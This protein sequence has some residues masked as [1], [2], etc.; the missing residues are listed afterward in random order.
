VGCATGRSAA[1][2]LIHAVFSHRRTD[3]AGACNQRKARARQIRARRLLPR[4]GSP[5]RRR[6]ADDRDPRMRS[7]AAPRPARSDWRPSD[8][9][10][11]LRRRGVTWPLG[12]GQERAGRAAAV[13]ARDSHAGRCLTAAAGRATSPAPGR[14]A[15]NSGVRISPFVRKVSGHLMCDSRLAVSVDERLR[16]P[17]PWGRAMVEPSRAGIASSVVRACSRPAVRLPGFVQPRERD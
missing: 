10:R 3:E 7:R 13:S 8:R 9:L 2:G 4:G 5:R 16:R 11:R 12:P 14:S 15:R 17:P 6:S 1:L